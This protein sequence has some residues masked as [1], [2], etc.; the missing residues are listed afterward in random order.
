MQRSQLVIVL[1]IHVHTMVDEPPS[2]YRLSAPL[3]RDAI[4]STSA[5]TKARENRTLIRIRRPLRARQRAGIVYLIR[6]LLVLGCLVISSAGPFPPPFLAFDAGAAAAAVASAG[7]GAAASV[8]SSYRDSSRGTPSRAQKRPCA[9]ASQRPRGRM[10]RAASAGRTRLADGQRGEDSSLYSMLSFG[11]SSTVCV[12][13]H[14]C[15]YC[16]KE[17]EHALALVLSEV[18]T[19]I[20]ADCGGCLP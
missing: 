4:G 2:E 3:T 8:L 9:W 16:A 5:R 6:L 12:R 11:T 13:T 14:G 10:R 17:L 18:R 20:T 15:L 7:A 19:K 1:G